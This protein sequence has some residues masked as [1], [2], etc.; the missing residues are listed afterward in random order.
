M[1]H[2][3]VSW[4]KSSSAP[5]PVTEVL[6]HHVLSVMALLSDLEQSK[7]E[8]GVECSCQRSLEETS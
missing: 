3:M 6:I 2:A 1:C 7:L 4:N 5:F 8:Q